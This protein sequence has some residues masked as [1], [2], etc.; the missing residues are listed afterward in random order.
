MT[1]KMIAFAGFDPITIN[2]LPPP[3]VNAGNGP[4]GPINPAW[5]WVPGGPPYVPMLVDDPN[6][7]RIALPADFVWSVP[8][9]AID[10]TATPPQTTSRFCGNK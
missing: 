10:D 4:I 5:Y 8:F 9:C 1:G 7:G 3:Q 6:L 2:P